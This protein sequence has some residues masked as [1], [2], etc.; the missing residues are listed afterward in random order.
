[1]L[2]GP[3]KTVKESAVTCLL[4]PLLKKDVDVNVSHLERRCPSHVDDIA[5]LCLQLAN[6]QKVDISFSS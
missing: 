5:H 6:S 2:Y 4:E 3:V 1:M